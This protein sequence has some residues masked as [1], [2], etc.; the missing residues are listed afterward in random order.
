MIQLQM[1]NK[2]KSIAL[3]D[4]LIS[5][6]LMYGS[7]IKDEGD[8]YSDIEFYIFFSEDFDHQKWVNQIN[9][10]MLYFIN[11]HG[12]EVAIFENL[13]RGEFHFH[14]ISER[15]V[16]QTWEGLTSFE[17]HQNMILVDK[18]GVLTKL[19]EHISKERPQHNSQESIDWISMSLVNQLLMTQGLLKRGEL[20]HAQMSFQ[21]IQKYLLWLIRI[22]IGDERH[23]ESPTKRAELE[24]TESWY[25]E[26]AKCTPSLNEKSLFECFEHTLY[27]LT[28]SFKRITISTDLK[29][30][31]TRINKNQN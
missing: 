7:F 15:K 18:D 26:Y 4:E 16:I 22:E 29:L 25:S 24:I 2:I 1:I 9:K 19:L 17:Y 23:W 21:S 10:T 13:I 27:V 31:L 12:T 8:Q 3:D 20:A 11:E 5:S 28:N 6:I 14:H 30:L